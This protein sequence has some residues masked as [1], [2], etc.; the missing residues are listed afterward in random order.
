M[1]ARLSL[2]RHTAALSLLLTDK[3]DQMDIE[4]QKPFS[5]G[6]VLRVT[7]KHQRKS[8]DISIRKTFER[9]A[10]FIGDEEKSQEIFRTL[11]HLHAMRK[12]IDDFLQSIPLDQ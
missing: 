7:A 5:M 11:A 4:T 9:L 2:K 1:A 6:Y 12:Q 8:V 3:E 10:E